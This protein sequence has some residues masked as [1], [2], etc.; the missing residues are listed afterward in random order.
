M[1]ER[2]CE[3]CGRPALPGRGTCSPCMKGVGRIRGDCTGCDRTGQLLDLDLRCRTCRTRA[4]KRCADCS[5]NN[6]WLVGMGQVRVCQ[7]CALRHDLD[8]VLPPHR[9]GALDPLRPIILAAEPLTTRRWLVRARDLL[10]GLDRGTFALNHAELDGLPNPKSVEHLR[11]LLI[12]AA[13]LPPDPTRL[14]RRLEGRMAHLTEPL[15]EPHRKIVTRWARWSVLPRLVRRAEQGRDITAS[16]TNDR[17]KIEQTVAFLVLVQDRKRTLA[18]CTQHDVDEWFAGP[19]AIR[20][21]VRPFLAWAQGT[22]LLDAA[23]VLP[24]RYKGRTLAAIDAEERWRIARG[25]L[26]NDT[27]DPADRVAGALIALYAQPLSRIVALTTDDVLVDGDNVRLKLGPD[28]LDLPEPL[29]SLIQALPPKRRDSTA[30]H[31][32]NPWLF[33]GGHA[34]AHLRATVLGSR[35]RRAGI[36]PRRLRLAALDQ[37]SRELP[38]AVLGGVLGLRPATA[39]RAVAD[40]GGSWAAYAAGRQS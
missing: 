28:P 11:A 4:K 5:A 21:V 26:S 37:L 16:V 8:E 24:S 36:E 12:S 30:Q 3:I 25:L 13:I 40:A 34:G 29:A 17:R 35:L 9:P 18:T 20:R 10:V 39:A 19:G 2:R 22:S 6:V 31:V 32:P 33:A 7:R 14:V 1:S 27:I 38:P 15:D 23:I